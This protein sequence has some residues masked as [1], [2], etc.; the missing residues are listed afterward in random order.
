MRLVGDDVVSAGFYRMGVVNGTPYC[1]VW[2]SS[3]SLNIPGRPD[4]D[5]RYIH[6]ALGLTDEVRKQT[7]EERL[8]DYGRGRDIIQE[9][10]AQKKR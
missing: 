4:L 8:A 3:E 5:H 6:H 9:R 10:R 7:T 2:G 1:E